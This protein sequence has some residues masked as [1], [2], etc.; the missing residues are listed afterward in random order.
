MAVQLAD[1][2]LG[3]RHQ[4]PAARD[5]HGDT[6]PGGLG[7]LQGPWPGRADEGG[8]AP[9]GQTPT[10]TWLLGVDV[11]AWPLLQNDVVV[12]ADSGEEWLVVSA[13]LHTLPAGI[14][15]AVNYVRVEAHLQTGAGTNP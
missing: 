11:Q 13:N 2:R 3:V 15:P 1:R 5:A 12:D 7:P 8:D 10:R 9:H 6:V 4:L 14:D